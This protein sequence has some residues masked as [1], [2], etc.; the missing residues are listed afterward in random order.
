M[1]LEWCYASNTQLIVAQPGGERFSVERDSSTDGISVIDLSARTGQS[2]EPDTT[3]TVMG[4][5]P[6]ASGE[7]Q[8][9]VILTFRV[10]DL[11]PGSYLHDGQLISPT[12]WPACAALEMN[13]SS[14]SG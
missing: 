9:S 12:K 5:F 13:H 8:E 4:T 11:R 1:Q 7:P 10:G 14:H 3:L 2:F 6:N